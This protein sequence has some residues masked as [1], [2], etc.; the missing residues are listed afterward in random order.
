MPVWLR[1]PP[2]Q[3]LLLAL[4]IRLPLAIGMQELLENVWQREFVVEGDARGYWELGQALA[5]G[6][7]YAFGSPPRKVHRMPG[8]PLFLSAFARFVDD[9]HLAPRL[10]LAVTGSFACAL[11]CMLGIRFC[12]PRLGWWAGV[13]CAVG[14]LPI[15]FSVV[16]LSE[17]LFSL[18]LV[19]TLGGLSTFLGTESGISDR[20]RTCW[21]VLTGVVSGLTTLVRPGWLLFPVFVT[22]LFSRRSTVR[23]YSRLMAIFVFAALVPLLPWVLR[24]HAVT[25]VPVVTT[26]WSGPTLYDSFNPE[27]DGGSNMAFLDR[28]A[29]LLSEQDLDRKYRRLALEYIGSNPVEILRLAVL[30]QW[31]FWSPMPRAGELN[32]PLLWWPVT[33]WSVPFLLL[34]TFGVWRN[35]REFQFQVLVLAPVVYTAVIHTVFVGSIRYRVPLEYPLSIAV[36]ASLIKILDGIRSRKTVKPV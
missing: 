32:H 18:G 6:K 27:A 1:K 8:F 4:T 34:A 7:D 33:L 14:P 9:C 11:V 35:C 36:A 29:D 26:L 3:I 16:L 23:H 10:G 31:R 2:V 15:A 17:T 30:K 22:V 21:A 13:L 19:G 20:S 24:N 28:D 5:Q 12:S 25:G